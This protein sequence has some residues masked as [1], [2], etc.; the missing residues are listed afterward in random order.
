MN[1]RGRS[2]KEELAN[3]LELKKYREENEG[4]RYYIPNCDKVRQW[5]QDTHL[6]RAIFGGNRTGKTE[7]GGVDIVITA[8]GQDALK[9]TEHWLEKWQTYSKLDPDQYQAEMTVY[10]DRL[11]TAQ[12]QD[13]WCVSPSFKLQPK[14]NQ[15]KILKYLPKSEIKEIAYISRVEN[16]ISQIILRNGRTITFKSYEQDPKDFQSAGL[17]LIWFDEEPPKEIWKEC[18]V[19]QEAGKPTRTILTETPVQGLTWIYDEV[20]LNKLNNP[21]IFKITIGWDDNPHLTEEQK[22]IMSSGL[23]EDE[24]KIRREGLFIMKEGLVYK[25]FNPSVHVIPRFEPNENFTFYRGFDFG[26]AKDHPFVAIFAAVDSEGNVFIY[27]SIYLR[28]VNRLGVIQKIKE[29][30]GGKTFRSSW[31]DSARPDWIK[32]FNDNGITT[33]KARKDVEAG[34]VKVS[35]FLEPHPLTHRPRLFITQNNTQLI[36]EFT[37]YAYPKQDEDER[38][39]RLPEKRYDDGLDALRY[40][41]FTWTTPTRQTKNYE[42]TYDELGRP[43]YSRLQWL[44]LRGIPL[45]KNVGGVVKS[46]FTVTTF[47]VVG[48][49]PLKRWTG[50]CLSVEPVKPLNSTIVCTKRI[51]NVFYMTSE[52]VRTLTNGR[53]KLVRT[54]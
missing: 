12:A 17:G 16:I 45:S 25:N 22:I 28:E 9:Y 24:I 48:S 7:G 40:F 39:K 5:H 43:V 4:L 6:I 47:S 27:D 41:I 13:V 11:K 31:G 18:L 34:I 10:L 1:Q 3:L 50:Q 33:Y 15:E 46:P 37:K 26:F 49:V 36:E 38:G 14:G 21:N 8:L 52:S 30:S 23:T 29:L 35:E 53:Q 51:W 19:R 54:Y 42:K 32:E 20:Y 44:N 2:D